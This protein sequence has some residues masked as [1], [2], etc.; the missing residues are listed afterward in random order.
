VTGSNRFAPIGHG[1]WVLTA[2][3]SP[4]GKIVASAGVATTS[5]MVAPGDVHLYSS[6]SGFPYALLRGHTKRVTAI[7]FSADGKLLA[8]G[9]ADGSVRL[10]GV[11]R[12]AS[13]AAAQELAQPISTPGPVEPDPFVGNWAAADP[14]DGSN[15]NLA[16][17]RNEDG[18]YSLTLIDDGARACGVDSAGQPKFGITVNHTGTARGNVLYAAST[19]IACMSTPP[20]PLE[21]AISGNFQY[22]ATTDTLWDSLDQALWRRQ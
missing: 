14:V 2:A 18:S 1:G 3:F 6:V 9:S 17:T 21:V 16:I 8:S 22:D 10:W 7:A 13:R 20:T 4:D 11:P 12:V 5:Y 15:M 19:S